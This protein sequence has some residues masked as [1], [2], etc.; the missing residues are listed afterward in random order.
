MNT[1]QNY[2][3]GR[4]VAAADRQ[5]FAGFSPTTG[6]IWGTFALAGPGEVDQAV[7]AAAAAFAAARGARCRPPGAGG[8]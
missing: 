8:C 2:I 3:D 1:Y 6:S 4:D 5:T 7:K